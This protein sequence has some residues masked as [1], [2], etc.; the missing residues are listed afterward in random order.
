[1]SHMQAV[2]PANSTNVPVSRIFV[3][4]HGVSTSRNNNSAA[5][6]T[7]AA[8]NPRGGPANRSAVHSH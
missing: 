5:G 8:A 4:L 6:T 3:C 7:V 1:M 2:K